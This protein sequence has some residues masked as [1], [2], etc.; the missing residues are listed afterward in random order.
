MEALARVE[1]VAHLD[2]RATGGRLVSTGRGGALVLVTGV[3]DGPLLEVHRLSARDYGTSVVMI[4]AETTSV[5][6]VAF[7]R[8]GATTVPVTPDGSWA[9]AWTRAMER[10]WGRVSSG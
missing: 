9:L 1:A 6:E 7:H 5:N 3:P 8:A 2:L 4:A 10:T